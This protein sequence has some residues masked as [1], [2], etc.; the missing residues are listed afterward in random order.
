MWLVVLAPLSIWSLYSLRDFS[1][2]YVRDTRT[3]AQMQLPLA[4][5][6]RDNTSP[7]ARIA[8]HDIGIVR[9]FS[10]RATLDVVGL[11]SAGLAP[12]YRNGP[13]S[14][15]ESLEHLQTD[16]YAVYPNVAPPYFGTSSAA[17]LL[18]QELFR[19][20]LD[21]YSRYTSAGDTQVV[22]RPDWSIAALADTPQQP[23]TRS[24][25]AGLALV[26]ALDIADLASEK[27][28][29]YDWWNQG[30]PAGFPTDARLMSY[31][32][33]A[34]LSL[35][36]GGRLLTGGESFTL[37]VKPGLAL[38]L[39][40]RLHQT[41]A[42][43]LDVT[44]NQAGLGEWRLP[45]VPGE[46]LESTFTVSP[47]VLTAA[48]ATVVLT[49]KD[50]PADS[51]YSP[52]YYWAYQGQ[53]AVPPSPAP[54]HI[55]TATFGAVAQLLGFDSSGSVLSPGQPLDLTLYWRAIAPDRA[56]YRV[57]VHLTD[58]SNDTAA[59]ILAQVDEAPRAGAFPFWVWPAGV[60]VREPVTLHIPPQAR[61]GKYL[62][63]AGVY[64]FDT[65]ARLPISGAP[66]FGSN[67]L[68]LS[69]IEIR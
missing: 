21:D 51:R 17:G 26:D 28:H 25:T 19:V 1:L 59:G 37:K 5:W 7:D 38:V 32:Q 63:L 41:A 45:A 13:G 36:D 57:F 8:A 20:H 35:A 60:T 52:F 9:Y 47:A 30:Q 24:E 49:V 48:F 6:L 64:D 27:A 22:T 16:F 18:G 67:R 34:G 54:Q 15:Y 40:A 12:A 66:D 23:S 61:P 2:E 46:W 39:V 33:D 56:N 10:G 31:R 14:L 69:E 43:V 4:E 58:P 55:L 44:V 68:L 65:G 62:L 29:G 42:M 11:T 53:I 50:A 3:A